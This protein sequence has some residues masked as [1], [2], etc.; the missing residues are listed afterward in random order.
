MSV[1]NNCMDESANVAIKM[2]SPWFWCLPCGNQT[3]LAGKSLV[4][5]WFS[6]QNK[7]IESLHSLWMFYHFLLLRLISKGH[8]RFL[9]LLY[10]PQRYPQYFYAN[11]LVDFP[12]T[13]K[14]K[15]PTQHRL[16][17]V[18]YPME[19]QHWLVV[20][21]WTPLKKI[22]VRQLGWLEIP[23][24][25]GKIKF[26]ATIHHQPVMIVSYYT[27]NLRVSKNPIKY[28]EIVTACC[29][30]SVQSSSPGD[31][32][33]ASGTQRCQINLRTCRLTYPSEKSGEKTC[34]KPEKIVGDWQLRNV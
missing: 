8:I 28:H 17:K 23:K 19:N 12:M 22:R 16:T 5:P 27:M 29:L 1:Q 25:N 14:K 6:H 9:L 32:Q 31:V 15:I 26:M 3:W 30:S 34:G 13:F 18:S 24:K 33:L 4:C 20:G 11:N 2:I 7:H 10:L 21:V